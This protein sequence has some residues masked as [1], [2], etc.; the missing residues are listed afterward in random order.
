M[1]NIKMMCSPPRHLVCRPLPEYKH[2]ASSAATP[3]RSQ[4][5]A[6]AGV[7][8]EL[9]S[10]TASQKKFT[11]TGLASQWEK[12]IFVLLEVHIQGPASITEAWK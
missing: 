11:L 2:A 1:L 12:E 6:S 9:L 8:Q 3:G 7:I 10:A 4:I 5:T